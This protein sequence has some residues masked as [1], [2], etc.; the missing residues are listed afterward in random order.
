MIEG[1]RPLRG[2]PLVRSHRTATHDARTRSSSV[3]PC[4][5]FDANSSRARRN[6]PQYATDRFCFA[7]RKVAEN[8]VYRRTDSRLSQNVVDEKRDRVRVEL[9]SGSAGTLSDAVI[10]IGFLDWRGRPI[11]LPEYESR[12]TGTLASPRGHGSSSFDSQ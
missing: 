5:R 7:Q 10:L 1:S 9:V 6:S 8:G 11:A 3:V 12:C 2:G 4:S